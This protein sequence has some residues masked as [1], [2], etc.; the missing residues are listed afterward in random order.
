LKTAEICLEAITGL[1]SLKRL[2]PEHLRTE[3]LCLAAIK[4]D[5]PFL[6]IPENLRE[7]MAREMIEMAKN[8]KGNRQ[9]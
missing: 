7:R 8:T 3:E 2:I 5:N 6:I 4:K 9:D 1:A